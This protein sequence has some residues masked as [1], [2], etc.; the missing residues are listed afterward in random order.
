MNELANKTTY[1]FIMLSIAAPSTALLLLYATYHWD[2]SVVLGNFFV[3]VG[4][5]VILLGWSI[6]S[7]RRH[8]I[9]A[10]IG[11]LVCTYCLWQMLEIMSKW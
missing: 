10:I 3:G 7:V 4:L 6:C 1:T 11:S 9:R 8:K 5:W 2:E